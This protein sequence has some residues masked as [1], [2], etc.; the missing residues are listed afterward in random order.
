[1]GKTRLTFLHRP[2]RCG[3]GVFSRIL[4]T[5]E[6]FARLSGSNAVT[7]TDTFNIQGWL[8]SRPSVKGSGDS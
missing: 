8:S 2:A 1:M 5:Y 6:K 4:K 3:S 7:T